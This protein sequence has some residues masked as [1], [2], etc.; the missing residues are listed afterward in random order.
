LP[1]IVVFFTV[2][3][4]FRRFAHGATRRP[5]LSR[6]G[7]GFGRSTRPGPSAARCP[8][9]VASLTPMALDEVIARLAVGVDLIDEEQR[10]RAATR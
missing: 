2:R 9:G 3:G 10:E 4:M 8:D 1:R 6:P 5:P 7:N